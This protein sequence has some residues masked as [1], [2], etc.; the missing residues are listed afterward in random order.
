VGGAAF[1]FLLL[2]VIGALA[3][4]VDTALAVHVDLEI[5]TWVGELTGAQGAAVRGG[6]PRTVPAGCGR[7][8]E[9]GNELACVKHKFST[10]PATRYRKSG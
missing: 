9:V 1:A 2:V 3:T 4:V 6:A 5:L 10:S 8:W 7:D